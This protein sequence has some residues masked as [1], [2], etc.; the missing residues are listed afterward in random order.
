[1]NSVAIA[2]CLE[3]PLGVVARV[4]RAEAPSRPLRDHD[5]LP[6][7][8]ESGFPLSRL[9]S[10]GQQPPTNAITTMNRNGVVLPL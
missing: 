4:V 9:R 6:A 10:C 5:M 8:H 7:R 2:S 3:S 1:V